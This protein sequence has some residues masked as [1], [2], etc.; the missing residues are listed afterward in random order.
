M[1]RILTVVCALASVSIASSCPFCP[2]QGQTLAGEVAQAD[3]ILVGTLKNAKQNLDDPSKN[4]TEL[5]ITMVVKDHPYVGGRKVLIMPRYLPPDAANPDA[6]FIVFAGCFPNG[7]LVAAA[8]LGGGSQLANFAE[9][10][11]DPYR[12]DPVGP[13]GE[14]GAYLKAAIE[15]KDKPAPERL[16]FYFDYLDAQDITISGDAFMEFG[17]AEYKDVAVLAPKLDAK[18]LL[19]WLRDKNTPP[20]HYGLYGM[21]VGHCGKKEDAATLR[22]MLDEPKK[23][24]ATGIDGMLAGY[25]MLDPDAG[26]EY[27]NGLIK[28]PKND[29]PI[30]YAALRTLRFFWEYHGDAPTKRKVLDAFKILMSQIDVADMPIED[31]RKWNCQELSA[32][33]LA[34]GRSKP[35]LE[36][37]FVR[38]AIIKYALTV[39]PK[40]SDAA[41]LV[42]DLRASNAKWVEAAEETLQFE[43]EMAPPKK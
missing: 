1:N 12:G 33:I 30:R 8:A 21:L 34:L 36:N 3:L 13:K 4:T 14:L 39:A 2:S 9:Y 38:R 17:N 10:T 43:K 22:E 7:K 28:D 29:F 41:A 25:I 20:S 32:D 23:L 35:H 26:W 18:K 40:N 42:K 6:Q 5:H 37:P 27:L 31:M 16:R 24:Y 11:F 15:L 19:A